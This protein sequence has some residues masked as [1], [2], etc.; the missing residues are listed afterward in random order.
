MTDD[1][2]PKVK[3]TE[4][5]LST[6][7][8][9]GEPLDTAFKGGVKRG[10][11]ILIGVGKYSGQPVRP[12][13]GVNIIITDL[14][15]RPGSTMQSE[16]RLNRKPPPKPKIIRNGRYYTMA[17]LD[18]TDLPR[19]FKFKNRRTAMKFFSKGPLI[20]KSSK[21]FSSVFGKP[22]PRPVKTLEVKTTEQALALYGNIEK[23]FKPLSL[24]NGSPYYK[25]QANIELMA[26]MGIAPDFLDIEGGTPFAKK[27]V[28]HLRTKPPS[29]DEL[30]KHGEFE[31][32]THFGIPF[33]NLV[34][35]KDKPS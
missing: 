7:I 26:Q 5:D 4:T 32:D 12:Q 22:D 20:M 9:L 23:P 31:M 15:W 35:K 11:L 29:V 30:L 16:S 2:K 33:V 19:C 14:N 6:I 1:I 27:M 21:Q 25:T 10:E 8:P 17:T 24:E 3:V 34:A 13:D 18:C 28:D